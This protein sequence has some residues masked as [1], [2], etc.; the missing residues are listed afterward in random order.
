M[1]WRIF[2]TAL[3]TLPLVLLDGRAFFPAMFPRGVQ[4]RGLLIL[5]LIGLP[6]TAAVMSLSFLAMRTLSAAAATILLFTNPFWVALAIGPEKLLAN[7]PSLFAGLP[8]GLSPMLSSGD[9]NQ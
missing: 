4:G 3:M 7:D 6:N 9:P 2:V 1:G 8:Y 5:A